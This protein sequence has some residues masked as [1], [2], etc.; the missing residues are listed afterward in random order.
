[1]EL[2]KKEKKKIRDRGEK[3]KNA[4]KSAAC[5]QKVSLKEMKKRDKDLHAQC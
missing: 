2:S 3:L 5:M 1:V 4:R